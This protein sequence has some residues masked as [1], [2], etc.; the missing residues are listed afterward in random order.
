MGEEKSKEW[1]DKIYMASPHYHLPPKMT[2]RWVDL[3]EEVINNIPDNCSVFDVGSGMGHLAEMLMEKRKL[4]KYLGMD[5]SIYAIGY[6]RGKCPNL[7]F[8]YGDFLNTD[9][10]KHDCDMYVFCEVL[11]HIDFDL[12]VLS[13][14]IPGKKI[15][16]TLPTFDSAAH[17]RHFAVPEDVC[18]RYNDVIEFEKCYCVGG[19]YI[20][21]VG[22]VKEMADVK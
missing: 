6:S 13:R 16:V 9:F 3:W 22:R 5:F 15:I 12:E 7:D 10:K 21:G 2:D 11:E 19:R 4:S 17:V 1:Y 20:I 18:D 8:I 14:I